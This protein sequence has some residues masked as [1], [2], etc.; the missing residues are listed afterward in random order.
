LRPAL[1]SAVEQ[2]C[3]GI[4]QNIIAAAAANT[5]RLAH[6]LAVPV[7]KRAAGRERTTAT[8]TSGGAFVMNSKVA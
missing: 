8:A 4:I 2:Q 5:E 6:W 7:S 1:P 3:S